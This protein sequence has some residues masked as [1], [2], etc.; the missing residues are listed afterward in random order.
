MEKSTTI[1]L[2]ACTI[3][4]AE[5]FRT[6]T[7]SF[8]SAKGWFCSGCSFFTFNFLKMQNL[9]K[10]KQK[11][12]R[13]STLPQLSELMSLNKGMIVYQYY[14]YGYFT[15]MVS[16]HG[17][18]R[19]VCHLNPNVCQEMMLEKMKHFRLKRPQ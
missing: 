8:C 15:L 9:K 11:K 19:Y 4:A 1:K 10:E 16:W 5:P 17:H 12:L 14:Q 2:R 13:F 3:R 6:A 18:A 7:L